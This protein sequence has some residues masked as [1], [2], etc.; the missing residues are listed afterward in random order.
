[1]T[2]CASGK[3]DAIRECGVGSSE[4]FSFDKPCLAVVGI[5]CSPSAKVGLL[6]PEG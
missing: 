1:M 4:H 6:E 3:A 2:I 5:G